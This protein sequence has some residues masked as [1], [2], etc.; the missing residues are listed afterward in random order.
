M[1]SKVCPYNAFTVDPKNKTITY[2]EALCNGCGTCAAE[3]RFGALSMKHFTDD[4][5]ITQ[6]D[7]HLAEDPQDKVIVFACNWC[8]YAGADTCGGARLQYPSNQRLIRTMCSG[9]VHEEFVLG[10][11]RNGAPMVVVSGCHYVDCHYIDANRWTQKRVE[12]LWDKLEKLGIRPE[13]LLLE[14]ISA[15]EGQRFQKTMQDI[16]ELRKKVTKEEIEHTIKVLTEEEEKK[17]QKL[18]KLKQ[19][20]K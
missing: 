8:S 20:Q 7:A 18:E 16:E 5:I 11:F 17:K 2:V 12:K 14:W 6:I 9:R 3:C 4:Q 15:A 10:A 13:R 1:C 19:K